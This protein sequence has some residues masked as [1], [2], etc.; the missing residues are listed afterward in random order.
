[1]QCFMQTTI[2][3]S[4]NEYICVTPADAVCTF[5]IEGMAHLLFL[6]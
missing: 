5:T 2:Q 4:G 6:I 1:M 3:R